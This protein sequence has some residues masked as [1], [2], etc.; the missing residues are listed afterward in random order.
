LTRTLSRARWD[1]YRSLLE[2]ALGAGYEVVTVETWA[3]RDPGSD[4][5][6]VLVLRHDV[7]R[8]PG[9]AL[10]PAAIARDLGV[11]SSWYLRWCTSDPDV[12]AA[13]REA[14]GHVGFHYETLTRLS[15]RD[16]AWA[17]PSPERLAAARDVLRAEIECWR[18]LFGP[19]DSICPHGD[20]RVP[21]VSNAVLLRG[22]RPDD[23][24]VRVDARQAMRDRPVAAWT[25]DSR[26]GWTEG[27]PRALVARGVTPLLCLVHPNN[28]VAGGSLWRDRLLAGALPA[29]PHGRR[30]RVRRTRSE[31]PPPAVG[32]PAGAAAG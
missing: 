6:R 14:G 25:T 24:G 13:L 23:V 15:L 28:W 22:H 19:L 17:R 1:E 27:E 10:Q 3:E 11:P 9:A 29:P 8:S 16:P 21:G 4:R 12:V 2:D 31:A 32:R 7:D 26:R 20:T 30:T 5:G 18:A